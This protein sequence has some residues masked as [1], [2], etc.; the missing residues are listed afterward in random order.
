MPRTVSVLRKKPASKPTAK[1]GT[2]PQGRPR[3]PKADGAAPVKAYI[4]ALPG[5]K[6]DVA[7]KFDALVGR[8]VPHVRRAIKWSSPMYGIEGRGWFAA[9]GAFAKHVKIQFFRGADLKPVPPAGESK[10]MR[11]LDIFET[12][13]FDERLIASWVRQAAALPGWG[14]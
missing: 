5:W 1:K 3:I 4:S 9:F 7:K 14:K 13:T 6:K 11:S 8:E 2:G 10:L 12:D